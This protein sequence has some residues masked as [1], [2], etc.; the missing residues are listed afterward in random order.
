MV[1][2]SLEIMS[3]FKTIDSKKIFEETF[4]SMKVLFGEQS[5]IPVDV[6]L[7]VSKIY[8]NLFIDVTDDKSSNLGHLVILPFNESGLEKITDEHSF[9]EDLNLN[10]FEISKIPGSQ[11]YLFVYS[12]FGRNKITSA[13]LVLKTYE[14]IKELSKIYNPKT[15]LIFAE[16]VSETGKKISQKMNMHHYHTYDFDDE[17]LELYKATFEEF[18]SASK[19]KSINSKI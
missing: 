19:A 5:H 3:K 14:A 4:K 1:A 17:T 12:I 11:I 18:L 9:E 6:L 13:K 2:T 7:Q 8:P 16:V 10:D 15:S